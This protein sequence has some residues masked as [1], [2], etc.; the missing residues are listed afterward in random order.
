VWIKIVFDLA[1]LE[2]V[3]RVGGRFADE[4]K[5]EENANQLRLEADWYDDG[6]EDFDWWMTQPDLADAIAQK[7]KEPVARAVLEKLQKLGP[8]ADQ[9]VEHIVPTLRALL[10]LGDHAV[11]IIESLDTS[12]FTEP[13]ARL[14]RHQSA[15]SAV[16]TLFESPSA[17]PTLPAVVLVSA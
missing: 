8:L 13:C 7:A 10:W 11:P 15:S 17:V 16:R 1:C 4:N 3:R 5:T 2:L 6:T 12:F 14:L 9:R